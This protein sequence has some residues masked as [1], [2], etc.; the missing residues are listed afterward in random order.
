MRASISSVSRIDGG[1]GHMTQPAEHLHAGP[2]LRLVQPHPSEPRRHA[3]L[4]TP[5]EAAEYLHLDPA[6]AESTLKTFRDNYAL[7]GQKMGHTYMYHRKNLDALVD[8]IF[9]FPV[10]GRKGR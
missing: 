9:G 8:R 4:F 6:T 5:T 2:N 1:S 10:G 7:V 3:D